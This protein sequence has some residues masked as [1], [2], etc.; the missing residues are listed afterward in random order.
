MGKLVEKLHQVGQSSGSRLGFMG[1]AD[2]AA[3]KPRPAAVLVALNAGDSVAADSVVKAGVDAVLI[4]GW[5][6]DADISQIKA[7]LDYGHTVWGVEFTGAA[8]AAE[9]VQKAAAAA[10]ASFV[11][12][13]P[14]APAAV[15]FD[16][17]RQ[18][19]L[20]VVVDAPKDDLGLLLLRAEN[21]LQAQVALVQLPQSP[22]VLGKLTISEFARLR[23]VFE[24][25]RFPALVMLNEMPEAETVKA[26]VQLGADGIMLAGTT[27]KSEAA[28]GKQVQALLETLQTLPVHESRRSSVAIGGFMSGSGESLLPR[29]PGRPS[30]E[31]DEE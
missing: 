16:E 30:P 27:S 8:S 10:G 29:R 20:V 26:L 12:V 23:L 13:G 28:L 14:S 22:G 3:S 24:S 2:S 15:L 5:V 11:L 25:L 9:G 4:R 1:R 7:V 6:P 21:L 19:D 18:L 17:D 31:P